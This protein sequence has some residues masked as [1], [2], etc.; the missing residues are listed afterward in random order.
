MLAGLTPRPHILAPVVAGA[1]IINCSRDGEEPELENPLEDIQ[2]KGSMFQNRGGDP[3]SGPER[4]RVMSDHRNHF[5]LWYDT[6]NVWT[7]HFWQ[8]L[9]DLSTYKLD[10]SI[11]QFSLS[12]HLDGQ[13]LQLMAKDKQTGEYLWS[14]EAWHESLVSETATAGDCKHRKENELN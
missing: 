4:K 1:Q 2:M 10:M 9:L 6:E 13:P 14:F 7:F 8:H 5:D 12:G 11:R 3:L